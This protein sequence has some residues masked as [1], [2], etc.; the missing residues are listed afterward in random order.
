MSERALS[1]GAVAADYERFRPGYPER[2]VDEVLA[3]ARTRVTTA[4]EIGAGTGKATRVFAARDIAVTATD[5]DPAMLA[6]LRRHVPATVETEQTAF[7]DLPLDR[8]Y[9]LVFAAA[10]MHWT[11]PE[12]RWSRVAALLEPGGTFASFGGQLL[13]A[14]PGLE[15][16]VAAVRARFGID[17]AVP[18]PDWTPHDSTMQWPGAELSQSDLFT[19]VRQLEIGRRVEMSASDYLGHLGTISA[20]LQLPLSV[21]VQVFD[22]TRSVLPERVTLNGDLTLHL[23]RAA[24]N[25]PASARRVHVR[26]PAPPS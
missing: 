16:S 23:A 6:E 21:R 14:E 24:P 10:A 3:Y 22:Q 19:A 13:L 5:P 18:S 12:H 2:L 7:E 9:D 11:D 1:F 26:A 4:L 20:Y 25:A 17:D 15:K 8:P